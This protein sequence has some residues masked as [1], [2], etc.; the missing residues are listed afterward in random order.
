[1]RRL[2]IERTAI[3]LQ[4]RRCILGEEGMHPVQEKYGAQIGEMVEACHAIAARQYVTSHGGNLSWRVGPNEVL[5]TPTKVNKGRITPDD[6]VIVD[7]EKQVRFAAEG[8]RPT[9]EVYIHVGIMAR[10]PDVVSIIHAHPPWLTAFALS[11]PELLRKPF[12]PEPIIEVGPMAATEYAE[13]LTDELA[14]TFE[15]V[16]DRYNA[17]LMKNHGA[18]LVSVEGLGRCL[19]LFEMMEVTAKT[20]AVAEMLGGAR[21]LGSGDVEGLARTMRTRSL[22]MPGAPGKVEGLLDLFR[23]IM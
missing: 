6:I 2:L 13:P 11:K 15:P 17:F 7:M 3:G 1:M 16:I 12:L 5:I 22:P 9:G 14:R 10:R 4:A 19:E 23:D 21:P 18:L 8:R 20:V